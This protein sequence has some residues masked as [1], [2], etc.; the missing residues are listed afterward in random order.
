MPTAGKRPERLRAELFDERVQFRDSI[1]GR[2]IVFDLSGWPVEP[3]LRLMFAR[4]LEQAVGPLGACKSKSAATKSFYALRRFASV[5]ADSDPPPATAGELAPHHFA[6]LKL[7]SSP[8][9]LKELAT[10]KKLLRLDP[11][12]AFSA[13]FLGALAKATGSAHADGPRDSYTDR[14][15]AAILNA[16]RSE[17]RAARDRIRRAEKLLSRWRA[18]AVD[19]ASPEWLRG[20]VLDHI[21]AHGHTPRRT[22]ANGRVVSDGWL[23][24]RAGFATVPA[25]M[26]QL[27]LTSWDAAAFLVLLACLTGQNKDTIGRSR[28]V[29][30]RT[31]DGATAASGAVLVDLQKPRRG[32]Y[33]SEMTVPLADVPEWLGVSGKT[34]EQGK[35]LLSP[36]G[37]YLLA[38]ELGQRGREMANS[39][40][41]LCWFGD[42]GGGGVGGGLRAAYDGRTFESSRFAERHALV[43]DDG[44]P[45][46]LNFSALRLTYLRRHEQPVAHSM[47]THVRDYLMRDPNALPKH[48]EV[49]ASVLQAQVIEARA[50]IRVRTMTAE[51]VE[52]A[53]DDLDGT[54]RRMNL[55]PTVLRSLLS[56]QLTT[57]LAGCSDHENGPYTPGTS[58]RASFLLCTAC[59]CAVALPEHLPVQVATHDA[60]LAR[61]ADLPA[62]DWAERYGAPW[63]RLSELMARQPAGAVERARES[64]TE[65]DWSAVFRLL[66]R[67]LDA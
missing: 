33:K 17:I 40:K 24:Q 20:Q 49:I 54:A 43:R 36:L 56:G 31:D 12:A 7:R 55:A 65:D 52:A 18:G 63:A 23:L 19:E 34:Y 5:L 10:V 66:N 8:T 9:G 27:F 2:I 11:E 28:A 1:T 60:L 50:A 35:E 61:R 16:A 4:C 67:E 45:M 58:C 53:A 15:L 48:Q 42:R 14:E 41:L 59:P 46:K 38:V 29:H 51:E 22:Q 37:T 21:A 3:D 26:S 39:D 44:S 57:V 47:R 6:A 62:L 64:V 32:K 30:H 25:A 13:E